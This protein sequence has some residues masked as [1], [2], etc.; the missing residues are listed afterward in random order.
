M[1]SH[2]LKRM[3]P[4]KLLLFPQQKSNSLWVWTQYPAKDVCVKAGVLEVSCSFLSGNKLKAQRGS[5]ATAIQLSVSE[6]ELGL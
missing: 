1:N 2:N 3:K 6:P 4:R 5:V